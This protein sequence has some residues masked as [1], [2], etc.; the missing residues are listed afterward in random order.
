MSTRLLVCEVFM[1]TVLKVISLLMLCG[2]LF[3]GCG[4]SNNG[5]NAACSTNGVNGT[6]VNGVCS[7]SNG[8]SGQCSNPGY[9]YYISSVQSPQGMIPACCNT[10]TVSY[11]TMCTQANNGSQNCAQYGPG[12]Y[13]GPNGQCVP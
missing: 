3:V 5:N 11:Q 1:K 9:P 4:S 2:A 12:W 7:L 13:M 8:V 6:M 10:P